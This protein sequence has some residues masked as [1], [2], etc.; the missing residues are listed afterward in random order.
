VAAAEQ[1]YRMRIEM[2]ELDRAT[3][4]DV[5]DAE[6]TLLRARLDVLDAW[7]DHRVARVRLDHALGR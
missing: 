1:A 3:S 4:L 7:I 2:F 5:I 6:T